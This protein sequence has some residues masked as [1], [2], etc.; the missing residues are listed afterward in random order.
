MLGVTRLSSATEV[1]TEDGR[2][3]QLESPAQVLFSVVSVDTSPQPLDTPHQL[4]LL[5][6][7]RGQLLGREGRG[8]MRKMKLTI[9]I[10]DPLFHGFCTRRLKCLFCFKNHVCILHGVSMTLCEVERLGRAVHSVQAR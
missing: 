9:I 1:R 3:K 7:M 10:Y 5:Q 6:W 2:N 4:Q 8:R